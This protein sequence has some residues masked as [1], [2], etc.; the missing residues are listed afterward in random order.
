LIE[1]T[2]KLTG[3]G[4]PPD[5][6]IGTTTGPFN[7]TSFTE[8][9]GHEVQ[10]TGLDSAYRHELV[11]VE[12]RA[13]GWVS[14]LTVRTT[15]RTELAPNL[16]ATFSILPGTPKVEVR[17]LL[18]GA[19]V[20][21]AHLDAPLAEGQD[22]MVNDVHHRINAITYPYRDPANAESQVDY[23]QVDLIETPP[24]V[25]SVA[26]LG[27]TGATAVMLGGLV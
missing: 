9:I 19:L 15:D 1:F 6:Q 24:P 18:G 5:G 16:T 22:V 11:T 14:T 8:W 20:V 23:Q 26:P 27:M 2:V 25:V 17:A 10:I 21:T 4:K 3:R 7:E 13:D 12:N